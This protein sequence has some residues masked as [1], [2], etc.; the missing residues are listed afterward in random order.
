MDGDMRR[1][2]PGAALAV[3]AMLATGCMARGPY[4]KTAI[5]LNVAAATAGAM[6]LYTS[7][8]APAGGEGEAP[9]F[10]LG[11]SLAAFGGVGLTTTLINR[12]DDPS[13]PGGSLRP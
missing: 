2:G 4:R 3:L 6:M 11:G 7:R 5:V 10:L 8:D 1:S 12:S 9:V 13:R